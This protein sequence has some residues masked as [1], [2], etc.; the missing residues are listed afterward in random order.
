MLH[1][2][3]MKNDEQNSQTWLHR[4]SE[5]LPLATGCQE[6]QNGGSSLGLGH[7]P[8]KS[9][10][11]PVLLFLSSSFIV[12]LQQLTALLSPFPPSLVFFWPPLDKHKSSVPILQRCQQLILERGKKNAMDSNLHCLKKGKIKGH[13]MKFRIKSRPGTNISQ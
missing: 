11:L 3:L 4:Q 9:W 8:G 2:Q 10:L 7:N 5:Q 6:Q 12:Q 13:L 1:L